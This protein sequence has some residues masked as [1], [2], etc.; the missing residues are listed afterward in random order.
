MLSEDV[1]LLVSHLAAAL[2]RSHCLSAWY[3]RRDGTNR[4]CGC[5]FQVLKQSEVG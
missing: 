3:V 5:L 2:C 4:F 1:K